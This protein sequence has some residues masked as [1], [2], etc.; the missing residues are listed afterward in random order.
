MASPGRSTN[1][2]EGFSPLKKTENSHQHIDPGQKTSGDK[3]SI[4]PQENF[5]VT[6]PSHPP[7]SP[8]PTHF[9]FPPP[10]ECHLANTGRT[11]GSA[12][13][14]VLSCPI[15]RGF[16][17]T[18]RTPNIPIPDPN[19]LHT[20][21]LQSLSWDNYRQSPTFSQTRLGW[22]GFH[23]GYPLLN[24]WTAERTSLTSSTD[25]NGLEVSEGEPWSN[26]WI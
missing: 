5:P 23:T 10:P 1:A 26:N 6:L 21:L 14:S 12:R 18:P 11:P 3:P 15:S 7:S 25:P 19:H 20:N 2:E 8:I 4:Q 17:C 16:A 24:N 22:T 13:Q 9:P